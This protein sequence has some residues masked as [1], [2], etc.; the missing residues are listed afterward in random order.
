MLTLQ[1]NNLKLISEEAENELRQK[2]KN[3][4]ALCLAVINV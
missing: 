4:E 2:E 3:N 1:K